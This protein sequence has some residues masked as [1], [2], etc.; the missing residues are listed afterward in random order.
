MSKIKNINYSS[1]FILFLVFVLFSCNNEK[2]THLKISKRYNL[3][4]GV[5][6]GDT[7]LTTVSALDTVVGHSYEPEI[8]AFNLKGDSILKV[9]V[10][11]SNAGISKQNN[12]IISHSYLYPSEIKVYD[13][14][15]N[16]IGKTS[17]P[18]YGTLSL[19]KDKINREG[20]SVLGV[21]LQGKNY[22]DFFE[23]EKDQK[24]VY[25]A[26]RK[27]SYKEYNQTSF[28]GFAGDSHVYNDTLY[29]EDKCFCIEGK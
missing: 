1:L 2:C 15:L 26:A 17:Y 20:Y 11:F 8:V 22:L 25:N 27:S 6:L 19:Y 14:N 16:L 28:Q 9:I 13:N 29:V 3:V 24:L 5:L 7:L 4:S 21:V 12:R 10:P 23:F 18:I